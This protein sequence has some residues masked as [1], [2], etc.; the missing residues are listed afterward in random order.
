M[1]TT[2]MT[3]LIKR[4]YGKK[5]DLDTYGQMSVATRFYTSR[6]QPI[7]SFLRE[8]RVKLLFWILLAITAGGSIYYFNLLVSTEQ[9]VLAAKG[10]VDAL[11]QRRNDIS[12][13]LSKAALDYSKHE[14][15]VFT[16]VVALRS[17]LGEKGMNNAQ[18]E[19]L[20]NDMDTPGD[21]GIPTEK[22]AGTDGLS[23]LGRLLAVAEQYPDLKLSSNFNNLMTALIEVEKDLA[24]ERI[25][26]NDAVNIYTTNIAKFPLNAYAW[27]FGFKT[28]PYFEATAEASK[29]KPITY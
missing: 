27:T 11:Q 9:D 3:T 12:I 13:N 16:V 22:M 29:F 5:Y 15:S 8:K 20:I 10:K 6:M 24:G 19:A 14:R 1:G 21:G 2:H 18:I 28:R 26:F 23:V 17:L 4:V 25:K 7:F